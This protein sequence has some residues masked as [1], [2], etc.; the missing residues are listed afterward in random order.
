MPSPSRS[1]QRLYYVPA[2]HRTRPAPCGMRTAQRSCPGDGGEDRH[3]SSPRLQESGVLT[4][5]PESARSRER[6]GSSVGGGGAGDG[7]MDSC[8]LTGGLGVQGREPQSGGREVGTRRQGTVSSPRGEGGVPAPLSKELVWTCR[9]RNQGTRHCTCS[10][11]SA[12]SP[13]FCLFKISINV[14]IHLI[15]HS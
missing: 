12:W 2:R 9:G 8:H 3:K 1:C 6:S 11:F 4:E 5:E 13:A 7:L 15:D 10:V 14:S